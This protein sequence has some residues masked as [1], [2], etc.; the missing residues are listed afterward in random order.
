MW[1]LLVNYR[2]LNM[3]TTAHEPLHARNARWTGRGRGQRTSQGK[4]VK[5]VSWRCGHLCLERPRIFFFA[6]QAR[7]RTRVSLRARAGYSYHLHS[8]LAWFVPYPAVCLAG[9]SGMVGTLCFLQVKR[10]EDEREHATASSAETTN[11]CKY[12][13]SHLH[14]YAVMLN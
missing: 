1:T 8:L 3:E 6:S 14:L 7:W 4:S 12:I 2:G 5:H 13:S 11:A 10:P 9:I